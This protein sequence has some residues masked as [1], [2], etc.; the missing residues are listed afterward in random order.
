MFPDVSLYSI[1][2][3]IDEFIEVYS[4]EREHFVAKKTISTLTSSTSVAFPTDVLT[5]YRLYLDDELLSIAPSSLE[6]H[7]DEVENTSNTYD[8]YIDNRTIYFSTAQTGDL[9]ADC[10]VKYDTVDELSKDETID[11]GNMTALTVAMYVRYKLA[12][13]QNRAD[14]KT[15]Y[16]EFMKHY[17]NVNKR[18]DYPSQLVINPTEKPV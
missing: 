17:T 15:L 13:A 18:R 10:I 11:L 2:S 7:K 1:L 14:W 12:I 3:L 4:Y 9:T 16:E 5:I 8:C 6:Y